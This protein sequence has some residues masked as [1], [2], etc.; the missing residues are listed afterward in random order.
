MYNGI[1]YTN[2]PES[3]ALNI[4]G[5]CDWI[6]KNKNWKL[7]NPN[8]IYLLGHGRASDMPS[9]QSTDSAQLQ[10]V[11]E[12]IIELIGNF[13]VRSLWKFNNCS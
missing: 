2:D 13:S 8:S 12:E 11:K 9:I 4:E 5:E 6:K 7:Y 1:I 10:E 3:V